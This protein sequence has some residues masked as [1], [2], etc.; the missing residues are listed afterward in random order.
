MRVYKTPGRDWQ[1]SGGGYTIMQLMIEEVD[2]RPF[3]DTLEA[4]V[5]RPLGMSSSTFTNPLPERLH[6]RAATG[7]RSDGTRVEGDWPIYPEM[8]AAGLWTTPTELIEYAIDVQR[9]DQHGGKGLLDP[10]TVEAMLTPGENNH[11]LG[12]IANADTFGHGGADEGFRAQLTAWR[13]APYALVAM[14]NSDTSTVLTEFSQAVAREY[15]L[16]GYEQEVK[17]TVDLTQAELTRWE[18]RYSIEGFG[19]ITI[20]GQANGLQ[21]TTDFGFPDERWRPVAIDRFFST[22]TGQEISFEHVDGQARVKSG[23]VGVRSE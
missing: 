20:A 13:E 18:G 12:P 14:V 15:G 3:A 19:T 4:N 1:Y 5:L 23:I 16:P 22:A 10:A 21:S 17:R 11:G 2:G 9:V 8:A 7:Y 6:G